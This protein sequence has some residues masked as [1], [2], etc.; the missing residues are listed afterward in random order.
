MC[1]LTLPVESPL[2]RI[3]FVSIVKNITVTQI[4]FIKAYH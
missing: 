4:R 1:E 3:Q 2:M